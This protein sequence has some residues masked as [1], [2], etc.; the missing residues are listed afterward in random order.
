MFVT[1]PFIRLNLIL[2]L[3]GPFQS[4]WSED[5]RFDKA[6]RDA[7]F[8]RNEAP[9]CTRLLEPTGPTYLKGLVVVEDWQRRPA[10]GQLDLDRG[11]HFHPGN[12]VWPR[13]ITFKI[14]GAGDQPKGLYG[15]GIHVEREYF[16][17][18]RTVYFGSDGR[19]LRL[20]GFPELPEVGRNAKEGE[21]HLAKSNGPVT[22]LST[23][24]GPIVFQ[25]RSIASELHHGFA[26]IGVSVNALDWPIAGG[27]HKMSRNLTSAY[28]P[29]ARGTPAVEVAY[30]EH[31][32]MPAE[33]RATAAFLNRKINGGA[34]EVAVGIRI[35]TPRHQGYLG[36][37]TV[38]KVYRFDNPITSLADLR[39]D[40]VHPANFTYEYISRV[41]DDPYGFRKLFFSPD[42]KYIIGYGGEQVSVF[43]RTRVG[44]TEFRRLDL[45]EVFSSNSPVQQVLKDIGHKDYGIPRVG[46]IHDVEIT[47]DSRTLIVS[48][49]RGLVWFLDL[50][51]MGLLRKGLPQIYS[52]VHRKKKKKK[53][54][55][56]TTGTK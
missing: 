52:A 5:D 7:L 46:R 21:G 33:A 8:A 47:P 12:A 10:F 3:M 26:T 23:V 19:P 45:S 40:R 56:K 54:K 55:K 6:V 2:I 16:Q 25:H 43:R 4:A 38:L 39:D 24:D 22:L 17:D 27:P 31:H 28:L 20:Q 50:T 32:D 49:E 15:V 29:V 35:E 13:I 37:Q 53:K 51:K 14:E 18:A 42:G 30:H 36:G 9:L 1:N 34:V 44:S 41:F 48:D 11:G